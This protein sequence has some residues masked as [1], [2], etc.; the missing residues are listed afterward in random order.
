MVRIQR[1][2]NCV[3]QKYHKLTKLLYRD[4]EIEINNP[5]QM[6]YELM[7]IKPLKLHC[8]VR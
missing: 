4:R 8:F 2:K 7:A 1:F 5:I 6:L 3:Y